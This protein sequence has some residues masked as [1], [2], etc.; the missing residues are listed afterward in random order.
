MTKTF[1]PFTVESMP[2]YRT[3]ADVKRSNQEAGFHFFDRAT[4]RFFDSRIESG[5]YRGPGGVYFITSEQFHGSTGNQARKF[6]VR[7]FNT[8]TADI[9][10]VDH[11]NEILFI[12]DARTLARYAAKG[13]K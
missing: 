6:T 8:G 7:R 5:L 3:M 4:M 12:E 11:F 2:R 9:D 1:G 10:T 13:G